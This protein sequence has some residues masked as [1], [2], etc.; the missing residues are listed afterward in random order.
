MNMLFCHKDG[1]ID[2]PEQL[3]HIKKVL[4]A[5]VGDT[6][7]VG[8]LGVGVGRGRVLALDERHAKL[9]IMLNAPPSKLDLTVLLGLP[10]PNVLRRLM[11]DLTAAGVGKII[12]MDTKATQ[13]SYWQ[14]SVL[15]KIDDF[16]IEGLRQGVDSHA[17]LVLFAPKF[18][19]L[20]KHGNW[21][22][23]QVFHP[24][25]AMPIK[26]A[27]RPKVFAIGAEGGFADD[28]IDLMTHA[29]FLSVSVGARILRTEAAVNVALGVY[30]AKGF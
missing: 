3:T 1:V 12:I 17:P 20:I 15:D 29:G 6:L 18:E 14:S 27:P 4:R 26:D 7:K 16:V 21:T 8:V 22:K 11:M 25:A 19:D 2:D 28:E 23:A 9:D 13:K 5:R 24:Y 30:F 10:R